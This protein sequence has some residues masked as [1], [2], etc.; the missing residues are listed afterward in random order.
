MRILSDAQIREILDALNDK[1]IE[2]FQ[3]VLTSALTKYNNDPSLIPE[4]IVVNRPELDGTVHLFMPAFADRVGV[5]TLA[6]SKEGF[7]GA[8]LVIDET[9]GVLKGVLNAMTLTAFRT[10]LAST[11]PLMRFIDS[12][13]KGQVMTVFGNGLQAHWHVKLAMKL[14]PGLFQNV[15]I[16]VRS[17]NEKAIQLSEELQQEFK[18]VE[19]TLVDENSVDLSASSVIFGCVPSTQ[20]RIL[21]N[22]L[23]LNKK[24]YISIIGSYKPHMSEVDDAIVQH[25]LKNG[26]II[27]DSYEHT[28]HEAG[29]LI[30]NG[31]TADDCVEIGELHKVT[32]ERV[33]SG[34]NLTL[35]KIVGLAIMDVSV[36]TEILQRADLSDVG[37]L[38]DF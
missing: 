19:I 16:A 5:K 26:K 13:V 20:P 36:G 9:N 11:V 28:L 27:V 31:I 14:F 30:K 7:K 2:Q 10:A 32:N 6:G 3:K 18:D 34:D 33:N 25:C 15:Q 35:C 22:K 8:V 12:D 29:E 4:R 21:F 38:V 37:T 1:E 24:V 17:I 23:Q